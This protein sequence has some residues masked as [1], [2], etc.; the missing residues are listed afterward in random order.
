MKKMIVALLVF[1]AFAGIA[2]AQTF[3]LI[4]VAESN[5]VVNGTNTYYPNTN[6]ARNIKGR[7][8][9]P[10]L[11]KTAN[12]FYIQDTS[13]GI[14]VYCVTNSFCEFETNTA[15]F[16]PGVEITI[17]ES[18]IHQERGMRHIQPTYYDG[19]PYNDFN[20]FY[21][22][23]PTPAPVTPR[24]LSIPELLADGEK[25]EGDLIRITNLTSGTLSFP[26][27][28]SFDSRFWAT[29]INGDV[30][31]AIFVI[32]DKDT[33]IMGQLAPTNAFDL[34]GIAAQFDTNA[35][36]SN[37]YE[38]ILFS[39]E[40]I[41][42]HG[43]GQEVPQLLVSP[44]SA[45][46]KVG[47]P[48]NVT[49]IGQDRNADDVLTIT[50]NQTIAGSTLTP[51]GDRTRVYSWT[52]SVSDGGNTYTT[53]FAVTDGV[54]TN[55]AQLV[56][57]VSTPYPAGA[58]W[59]NEFHYDNTGTDADEGIE[60]AGAAGLNLTGY[61]I[62]LYNGG[63]AAPYGTSNLTGVVDD[64]GNGYGALWFAYPV[65][66][67]Q[68]GAPDGMALVYNATQVLD[69][70]SYEGA[71]A[72]TNGGP[73][74]G[75][76]SFDVGVLEPGSD[77]LG[78]S[79]Q[80]SGD[81]TNYEAFTWAGPLAHTRGFLNSPTQTVGGAV[82]AAVIMS[83]PALSP[84]PSTNVPFNITCTIT[85]NYE[86]YGLLATA[87]YALNGG[88]TNSITM[89]PVDT[90]YTTDSQVS[91]QPHGTTIRYWV[92]V[93]FSGTGSNSPSYSVTNSYTID[94]GRGP[95]NALLF[96]GFEG[97]PTDTW[98][99]TPVPGVG[100]VETNAALFMSGTKSL[101]FRSSTNASA[102]PSIEFNNVSMLGYSN[103]QLSVAFAA[104]GADSGDDLFLD[105]SYDNGSTWNGTGS[106]KLVDGF[107][108]LNLD[109]GSAATTDRVP[110][111]SNPYVFSIPASETQLKIRLRA[112]VN[113]TNDFL[114][115]DD[116][117]LTGQGA[118]YLNAPVITITNPAS[119][120]LVV[121]NETT[122][123]T[124]QG[125][126]NTSVVG[127]IAWTNPLTGGSG[128][129]AAGTSWSIAS[130]ALNAGANVITVSGTNNSGMAT[131]AG[132]TITRAPPPADSD[133]MISE[134]ADTTNSNARFVEIF[135]AGAAAVD[136]GTEVYYLSRQS[137]GGTTWGDI[138]LTN[139]TLAAGD[140]YVVAFS[141][142]DFLAAFGFEAD[143]ASGN[144]NGNGNDG[145]FLYKDG[146]H[147]NGSLVDAYGIIDEDGTGKAWDYTDAVAYRN[148]DVTQPNTLWSAGEWTIIKPATQE[149]ATPGVH[150]VT[151][152]PEV[153]NLV[154]NAGAGTI[155]FGFYM[156]GTNKYTLQ[157]STNLL[158]VPP[159][160]DVMTDLN[161][162][163]VVLIRDITGDGPNSFY[164]I[165]E[166]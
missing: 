53:I 18:K 59:I 96:Q 10:F 48:L 163:N 112:A 58:P 57:T 136:F 86:A 135:N 41:I 79:L 5:L 42:Q 126:A 141:T 11:S 137:N 152:G 158:S 108:N 23:D 44:A 71:F 109:F 146:N 110:T 119:S 134:V 111:A 92:R 19:D 36:P 4:S 128:T 155:T 98:N 82:D 75:L 9:T 22:S 17:L 73:A 31:N 3:V 87:Y 85:P 122:T 145:Y 139:G 60:I 16:Q 125:T 129:L 12:E 1:A 47:R 15:I 39:Y 106:V 38:I 100:L 105:V 113:T 45:T 74:V 91:G 116:I 28:S 95:T 131:S 97:R 162:S 94:D 164:R 120:T 150:T 107:G 14:R 35:I 143:Q 24:V 118:A 147:T 160:I 70:I 132:V 151:F 80:L 156:E 123:Y 7:L 140:A 32:V 21:I 165:R 81:G 54:Y 88:V 43:V 51:S 6:L 34:I 124:V 62:V 127:Q 55:T 26:Y 27:G 33:D 50:T 69:F 52:P 161:Y 78:M 25:Y 67:L 20:D 49:V 37:G 56:V 68:N 89:S 63:T 130:I 159:F 153:T 93:T 142:N 102:S 157:R 117:A 138:L 99:F 121:P 29:N 166:Q 30:T 115:V 64:E 104:R 61:S 72:A 66:G 2:Q 103:A 8:T 154:L 84:V 114:F 101:S 65:N 149:Q 133:L 90:L 46:V 144:I 148:V 76:S 83:S 77:P 13:T 40:S